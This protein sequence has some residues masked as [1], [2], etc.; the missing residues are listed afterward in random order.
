M[1]NI[2]FFLLVP[3]LG[4]SQDVT[5]DTSYL[6]NSGG[7]FFNVNRI[8]YS[9]GTYNE[10]STIVGDT[11]A[12]VSLYANQITAAAQQYADAAVIAMRAQSAT[13]QL[14]KLDSNTVA[15]IGL[16]PITAVMSSYERDFLEGNWEIVYNGTTTA[17]TF[18]RLSTNQRIR[19]LPS[20]GTARTL[21][22]FGNILRIVNYPISG[23]NTLFKVRN[24]RWENLQRTI[25]L[26]KS[27][28]R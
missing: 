23:N 20:G 8:E 1:K 6:L 14:A 10:K 15:R 18:P 3:F 19:I 17:V 7:N 4:L 12:V 27:G 5:R 24:G 9:D 21:L 26:K 13:V 25:I 28:N 2:I 16:S 22:I 11:A